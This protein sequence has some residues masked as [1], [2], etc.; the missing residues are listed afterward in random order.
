MSDRRPTVSVITPVY[1]AAAALPRLMASLRAQEYPRERVEII[2]VDNDSTDG[3][4][5]VIKSFPDVVVLRQTAYRGPGATRNAG[6][7]RAQGDVL[8]FID[9]DCWA[10]PAWLRTGVEKLVGEGLDRVAGHVEFVLSPYPNL[11]ETYDAAINFRQTDFM[12]GG[13]CGTG[14]LFTRQG[15]F[16]ELGLF[17]PVLISCEDT[18]FG[19]RASRA[20]KTLGFAP[21]A[22]VYHQARTSLGA[23]VKKWI[24]TEYGA[25]Q[26]WKRHGLLELHLWSK[27]AN[28]RPLR[29]VWRGFPPEAR[30]S[31]RMRWAVDG[32]ANILRMAGN[33][34]S[35]LGDVR[36]ARRREGR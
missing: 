22:I 26:V 20:G 18:E 19:M 11:Y 14:N 12:E 10:H 35:F 5:E 24:R 27:K 33:L 32:I 23:L 8:A 34:G 30:R 15:L 6:I 9:A 16:D 17:D 36:T 1:N 7:E 21:G 13:W 25:A 3:S 31:G 28:Y 2:L 4:G 29:G